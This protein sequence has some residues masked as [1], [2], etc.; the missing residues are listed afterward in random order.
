MDHPVY[1]AIPD[2]SQ[3]LSEAW[4]ESRL[5][6]P[7]AQL[8]VRIGAFTEKLTGIAPEKKKART[9]FGFRREK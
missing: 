4:S 6:A 8:A 2:D 9:F 7:Q 5:V 1:F 3:A